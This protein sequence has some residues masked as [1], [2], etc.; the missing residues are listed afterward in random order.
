MQYITNTVMGD[1]GRLIKDCC[2][3]AGFV[4]VLLPGAGSYA[5]QPE[6]P[7]AKGRQARPENDAVK[8][9]SKKTENK[10]KEKEKSQG[11]S[12][13]IPSDKISSDVPV[14]FPAD[15]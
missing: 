9:R 8:G 14:S 6:D 3:I 5:L 15:I 4:M 1:K 13:F 2:K 11:K 10:Q 7:P 12:V